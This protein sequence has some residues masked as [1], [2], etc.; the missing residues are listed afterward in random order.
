MRDHSLL[1][2]AFEEPWIHGCFQADDEPINNKCQNHGVYCFARRIGIYIYKRY[3]LISDIDFQKSP[4][5]ISM[6]QKKTSKST[7]LALYQS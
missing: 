6:N 2:C 3:K 4:F 1:K 7:K 5:N